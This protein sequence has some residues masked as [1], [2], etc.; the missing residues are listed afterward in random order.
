MFKKLTRSIK[1]T[2]A[3]VKAS[4]KRLTAKKVSPVPK[5]TNIPVPLPTREAISLADIPM[6]RQEVVEEVSKIQVPI[7]TPNIWAEYYEA[8]IKQTGIT[9][10]EQE[11]EIEGEDIEMLIEMMANLSLDEDQPIPSGSYFFFSIDGLSDIQEDGWDEFRGVDDYQLEAEEAEEE[12]NY[13]VQISGDDA[14]EALAIPR[15][16]RCTSMFALSSIQDRIPKPIIRSLSSEI[17]L[18]A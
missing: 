18:T 5:S 4:L 13:T 17:F 3:K 1:K 14:I 15:L 11:E 16:Q 10:Q 7:V 6:V 12:S 2:F 8:P 9:Q